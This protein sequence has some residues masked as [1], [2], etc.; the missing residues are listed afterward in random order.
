MSRSHEPSFILCELYVWVCILCRQL[1]AISAGLFCSFF[2]KYRVENP[3]FSTVFATKMWF[4]RLLQTLDCP[5]SRVDIGLKRRFAPSWHVWWE[6]LC[7]VLKHFLYIKNKYMKAWL[8]VWTS[9]LAAEALKH[10]TPCA[11][12]QVELIW[13]RPLSYTDYVLNR[14]TLTRFSR[15]KPNPNDIVNCFN[16]IPNSYPKFASLILLWLYCTEV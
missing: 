6:R 14:M 1:Y 16:S 9:K 12:Q 11:C 10:I 13:L 2:V 8:Q 15:S 5:C 4:C 3:C 7:H